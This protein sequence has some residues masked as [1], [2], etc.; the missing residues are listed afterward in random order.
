LEVLYIS[1]TGA[2]GPVIGGL[3]GLSVARSGETT[4]GGKKVSSDNRLCMFFLFDEEGGGLLIWRLTRNIRMPF[5]TMLDEAE[6]RSERMLRGAREKE[7]D[8]GVE[9]GCWGCREAWV[10]AGDG[11][12]RGRGTDGDGGWDARL[13]EERDTRCC[14]VVDSDDGRTRLGT[15]DEAVLLR[16]KHNKICKFRQR[17]SQ[18]TTCS[19]GGPG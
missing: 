8:D 19:V 6:L 10:G 2:A 5:P 3:I 13:V 12:R 16:C 11:Q 15:D 1:Q 7:A 9:G 4:S 14:V 18:W 17:T